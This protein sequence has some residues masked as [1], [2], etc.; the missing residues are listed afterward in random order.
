MRKLLALN[1][2][3]VCLLGTAGA[4]PNLPAER[5]GANDLIAVAVYGAP[6]FSRTV[7]ADPDGYISLP[8]LRQR[9]LAKDRMPAELEVAIASALRAEQLLV[10]PAVAVTVAE[11]RSRSISVNGA[12][13]QAV[14]FQAEGTVTL[15]EALA[16]AGGLSPEAGPEILVSTPANHRDPTRRVPVKG[17][18]DTANPALNLVL[19]GGEEIRVPAAGKIFVIGNVRKPGV[20]PI[21]GDAEPTFLET[22]AAAEGLLPLAAKDAYIYRQDAGGNAKSEIVA[23]LRRILERQATDPKL[24]A[25][26]IVYIPDARGRRLALATIEKIVLFGSGAGTAAIYAGVR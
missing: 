12:V 14:T 1:Y 15:L 26:D 9:I 11:Y 6:E 7:R 10:D 24:R 18:I 2:A 23:P 21:Q 19:T 3:W 22:L 16:R 8:M 4:Q 25:N 13:R 5:I 20:Y 17:L